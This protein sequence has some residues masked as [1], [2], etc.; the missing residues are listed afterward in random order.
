MA[1]A[2]RLTAGGAGGDNSLMGPPIVATRSAVSFQ[3]KIASTTD[4]V[5]MLQTVDSSTVEVVR[6]T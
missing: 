1:R 5:T 2:P 6:A 3:A 4:S